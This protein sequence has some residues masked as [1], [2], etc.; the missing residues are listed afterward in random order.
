MNNKIRSINGA[1]SFI[2]LI[3]LL[4]NIKQEIII[5]Q[6]LDLKSS[7]IMLKTKIMLM[8]I[9]L[10]KQLIELI[11]LYKATVNNISESILYIILDIDIKKT[12]KS[13]EKL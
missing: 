4:L 1:K 9:R 8:K 12:K 10:S 2:V 11:L 5:K 7:Y 6:L 13:M 3:S